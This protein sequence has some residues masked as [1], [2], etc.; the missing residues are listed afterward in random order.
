MKIVQTF[1]GSVVGL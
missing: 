1:W